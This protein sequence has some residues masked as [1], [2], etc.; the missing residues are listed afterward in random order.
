M[1]RLAILAAAAFLLE[2]AMAPSSVVSMQLRRTSVPLTFDLE[3]HNLSAEGIDVPLQVNIQLMPSPGGSERTGR[4]V[5]FSSVD[6]A[7][8][9]FG[10]TYAESITYLRLDPGQ[11]RAVK[12]DLRKLRWSL[13]PR[14]T[15]TPRELWRMAE[16][17][18]YELVASIAAHQPNIRSETRKLRVETLE[19]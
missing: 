6:P 14:W 5:L 8:G 18:P 3:F 19:E 17:G 4:S 16:P 11:S 12:V 2:P 10:G 1:T 7:T 9:K 15:W 13:G